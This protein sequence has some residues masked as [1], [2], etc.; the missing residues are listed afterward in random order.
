M[1]TP[2]RPGCQMW[3]EAEKALFARADVVPIAQRY[4]SYFGR[5]ARFEISGEMPLPTSIRLRAN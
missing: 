4:V 2:G 5:G 1:P 3:A